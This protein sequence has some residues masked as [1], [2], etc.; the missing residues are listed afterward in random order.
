V[1]MAAD[2]TI[3]FVAGIRRPS[4]VGR[5]QAGTEHWFAVCAV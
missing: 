4:E 5:P 3:L 1:L 2:G